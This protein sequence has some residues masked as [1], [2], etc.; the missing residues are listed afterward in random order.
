ME[1]AQDIFTGFYASMMKDFFSLDAFAQR[2]PAWRGI[3]VHPDGQRTLQIYWSNGTFVREGT[4]L[5]SSQD[6]FIPKSLDPR[7][8]GSIEAVLVARGNGAELW[9]GGKGH[10]LLA[11]DAVAP[12]GPETR[13]AWVQS[14]APCSFV[15]RDGRSFAGTRRDAHF[16]EATALPRPAQ[17]AS[18]V[19]VE[20]DGGNGGLGTDWVASRMETIEVGLDVP[21]LLLDARALF[22]QQLRA[23]DS[24]LARRAAAILV[25]SSDPCGHDE[26]KTATDESTVERYAWLPDTR[27]FR[28]AVAYRRGLR[29]VV[30]RKIDHTFSC[31][32]GAPCMPPY[33]ECIPASGGEAWE[34][35]GHFEYDSAGARVSSESL[36][37]RHVT[38][39]AL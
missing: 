22:H 18:V 12:Q 20:V 34:L 17:E 8:P 37:L 15:D 30:A 10:P 21:A 16:V 33:S 29:W 4:R 1:D 27:R 36:P 25:P 9:Y 31:P 7:V 3:R 6:S 39:E 19:R 24:N 28:V 2:Q 38:D 11:T 14:R 23:E 35:L 32:P 13:R 26:S 5:P